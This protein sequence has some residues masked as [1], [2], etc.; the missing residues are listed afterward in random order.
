MNDSTLTSVAFD[1]ALPLAEM[2]VAQIAALPAA[3]LQEAHVNLL[4]LQSAI[5]SVLERFSAALDQR[6]AEQA[7]VARQASGRDFGV[8]HLADGPLRITVDVPKRVAWDQAQLGEIAQRIAAAGDK[9]G[10]FI[11]TDYSV[12]E[13][14]FNAW[15]STL[16]EAFAKARTVKPGKASYRLAL[17]QE[18]Q[19]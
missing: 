11:D 14:R 16:K 8:C 7:A 17:V 5:K 3:Q 1:H 13:S 6:Y 4:T 19:A 15:S 10:D 9:V 2:S 12:P 18:T